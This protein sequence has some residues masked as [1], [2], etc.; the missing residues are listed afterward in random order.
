MS[1]PAFTTTRR[2]CLLT[3]SDS[4][5]ALTSPLR[6]FRVEQCE[7]VERDDARGIVHWGRGHPSLAKL[8]TWNRR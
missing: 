6:G 7:V 5:M 3:L 4:A 8:G 2:Y 1:V